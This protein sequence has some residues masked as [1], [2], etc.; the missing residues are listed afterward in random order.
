[1]DKIYQ[2]DFYS[3]SKDK[4]TQGK[5]EAAALSETSL[6]SNY[7]SPVNLE[8]SPVLSFKFSLNGKDNEMVSGKNHLIN[9]IS[10]NGVFETPVIRF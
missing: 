9:I 3:L 6:S 8:I 10:D 1:M 7:Q 5:F 4:V 2:S